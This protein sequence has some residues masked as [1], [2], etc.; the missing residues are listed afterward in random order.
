[1]IRIT[2]YF[3]GVSVNTI[4]A[5]RRRMAAG[6]RLPWAA[7]DLGLELKEAKDALRLYR[8]ACLR[9]R[10]ELVKKTLEQRRIR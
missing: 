1:M 5:L 9:K 2:E 7:E 6:M 4:L 8:E 10:E 3:A